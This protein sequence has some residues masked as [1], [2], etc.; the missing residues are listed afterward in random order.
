[1]ASGVT[2]SEGSSERAGERARRAP[3]KREPRRWLREA[4]GI[5]LLVLAGFGM[6]AVWNHTRGV[7]PQGPVGHLGAWLG[8][9]LFVAFGYGGLLFPLSL[10]VVAV[11]VFVRPLAAR[12]VTPFAGLAVLL[13]SATGLM[14]QAAM[15]VSPPAPDERVIVGGL[16]GWGIVEALQ[17]ALGGVGT[18]LV[19]LAGI[20]IGV[21]FLTHVSYAALA[22]SDRA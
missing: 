15:T 1:M 10:A 14:T 13:L 8:W 18:W 5:L 2:T 11:N 6:V 4:K 19:L 22:R 9:S 7:D 20:P 12:G 21:S 16:V 17:L 3:K